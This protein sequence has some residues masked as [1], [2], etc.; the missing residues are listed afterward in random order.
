MIPHKY[1]YLTDLGYIAIQWVDEPEFKIV[2]IN[3]PKPEVNGSI[4]TENDKIVNLAHSIGLIVKGKPVSFDFDMFDFGSCSEFQRKVLMAEYAIPLGKVST[5]GRI[6]NHIGYPEAA[7][8]VGTAL[9]KNPFPLVIPCHRAVRADGNIG[10][11]QG[12][13]EMR[14]TLLQREG[15]KFISNTLVDISDVHY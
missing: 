1:S 8:A 15:V 9:A 13:I 4:S 7:R 12:G 11:Y 10:E 2:Q 14:R 3:L 6:A 5:Y